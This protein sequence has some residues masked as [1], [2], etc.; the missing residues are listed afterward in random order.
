[1]SDEMSD[2][3]QFVDGFTISLVIIKDSFAMLND[4]LKFVGLSVPTPA[5]R[6]LALFASAFTDSL[7]LRI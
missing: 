7:N 2:E 6:A 3:L 1:M 5:R 4:K